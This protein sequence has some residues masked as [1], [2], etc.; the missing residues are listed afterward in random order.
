MFGDNFVHKWTWHFRTLFIHFTNCEMLILSNDA[1][2]LLLQCV[3]DD[4]GSPWSLS[5][6]NICSP[7]CKHYAPFP[8]TGHVRNMFTIDRNKSLVN[9][10]WS[11]VLRLQKPNHASHTTVGGMWY[12]RVHCLNL[13]HSQHGNVCCT[14][15]SRKLSTLYW[16]H[17]THQVKWNNCAGC[18]RKRSLLPGYPTYNSF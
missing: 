9:F 11:N 12:Q 5:V 18:K 17:M 7:I 6:M 10:T 8:D 16:T 1:V 15:C 14:N 3:C 2:H 4:R 13:L